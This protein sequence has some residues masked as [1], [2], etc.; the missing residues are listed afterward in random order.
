MAFYLRRSMRVGPFRLN[1][2]KSGL[3]I[4]GGVT[5]ARIGMGPRGA[6]LH[7]GRQGLYYRKGIGKKGR[8]VY[9]SRRPQ[10]APVEAERS[11]AQARDASAGLGLG[12]LVVLALMGTALL[13]LYDPALGILVGACVLAGILGHLYRRSA[14]ARQLEGY[15]A[16]LD[17]AF[18]LAEQAPSRTVLEGIAEQRKNISVK[19]KAA[20]QLREVE[21]SAY[22]ATL[23]KAIDDRRITPVEKAL[24]EGAEQVMGLS[25]R[26]LLA[27]KKE[28]FMDAFLEFSEDSIISPEELG[29]LRNFAEGMKLP[30]EVIDDEVK[31]IDEMLR[32]QALAWPLHALAPESL[33]V[34][35]MRGESA[36]YEA[37]A[38]VLTRRKDR[39]SDCGYTFSP[40][41]EGTLVVTERRFFVSGEGSTV[42][43]YSEIADVEVDME[44]KLICVTK[45]TSGRPVYL[46]TAEPIYA[47]RIIDL[48]SEQWRLAGA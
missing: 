31:T 19:G 30:R 7:G 37:P 32:A 2:S 9:P 4:S 35:L 47:G 17:G 46:E 40:W 1:F 18:V 38:V 28:I 41:R 48:A 39:H 5:G 20:Q 42:V 24:L 15:K 27:V 12:T 44:R 36:F 29:I 13:F 21:V 43:R 34:N 26:E 10:S 25:E 11:F 33:S 22:L 8:A 45:T 14:Q 16:L 6:Y 23:D 3:G